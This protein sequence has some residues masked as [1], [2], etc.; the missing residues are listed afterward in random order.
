MKI[1]ENDE[2]GLI[3]VKLMFFQIIQIGIDFWSNFDQKIDKNIVKIW[4]KIDKNWWNLM[5]FYWKWRIG[6]E[7]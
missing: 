1:D 2:L 3:L 7:F 4:S 5:I 6:I